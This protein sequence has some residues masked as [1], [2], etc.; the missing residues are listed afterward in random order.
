[1]PDS[2]H[3]MIMSTLVKQRLEYLDAEDASHLAQPVQDAITHEY[4]NLL[5]LQDWLANHFQ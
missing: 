2:A 5:E 3:V 4:A 1:M